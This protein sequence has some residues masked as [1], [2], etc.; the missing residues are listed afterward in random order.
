[1]NILLKRTVL[2]SC[3]LLS[4]SS[5]TQ[6]GEPSIKEQLVMQRSVLNDFNN[7][8]GKLTPDHRR[9]LTES[10]ELVK[11]YQQA[12]REEHRTCLKIQ[13]NL[14]TDMETC[15]EEESASDAQFN[16]LVLTVEHLIKLQSQ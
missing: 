13:E 12:K 2:L 8:E 9:A 3:F 5:V 7:K 6:A 10:I 15:F 11:R 14:P 4:V 1:M 16:L